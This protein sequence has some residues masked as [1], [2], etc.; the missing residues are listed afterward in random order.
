MVDQRPAA[1]A[2]PAN[3]DDV[4]AAVNFSRESGLRVTPQRT[5]HN[6]APL[7]LLEDTLLLKTSQMNGVEVDAGARS[8]G[9]ES[10][11]HGWTSSRSPPRTA[12]RRCMGP[13][14]TSG[15]SGTRSG[16]ASACS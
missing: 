14:P 5:G 12:S 7:G 13:R 10:G 1:I 11:A 15:S 3:A 2:F 6:S 9:V 4:V 8:A 16:A